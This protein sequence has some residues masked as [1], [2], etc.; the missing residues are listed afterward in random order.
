MSAGPPTKVAGLGRSSDSKESNAHE[1]LVARDSWTR[2]L[3]LWTC[4]LRH[5]TP[6]KHGA[7]CRDFRPSSL[8]F[9]VLGWKMSDL[10][11]PALSHIDMEL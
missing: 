11:E 10:L 7:L 8:R 9:G 1:D 2:C 5:K 3:D 4:D 6:Q